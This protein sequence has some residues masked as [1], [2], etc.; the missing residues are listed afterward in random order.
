MV[1][2]LRIFRGW[3][4]F[5]AAALLMGL[6]HAQTSSSGSSN[7]AAMPQNVEDVLHQMSD[8]ADIIFLGQVAAIRP[9]DDDGMAAGFVEIDFNVEQPIRGCAGGSYVLREWAG[10]WSG[11]A[12]RYQIGQRRLM[13][14]HAPGASGMSSPVGGMDGAIPIRGVADAS[15]LAMAAGDPPVPVADLRWLGAKVAHPTSYVLQPTLSP[16]PL[17]MERQTASAATLIVNPTL[18]IDDTSA[19]A[20]TPAQQASVDALVKLLTSW[21]KAT[22]DVR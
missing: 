22:D 20:S 5:S 15:Q 4:A 8:R 21:K 1:R 17:N 11:D 13:M 10:L 3:L 18:S 9:S 19:R 12:R 6:A 14:L 2:N 16:A 7:G